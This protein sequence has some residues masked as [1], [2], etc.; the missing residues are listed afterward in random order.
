MALHIKRALKKGA[1]K[2]L[3]KAALT[4]II[5]I[6]LIQLIFIASTNT[7]VEAFI[8]SLDLPAGAPEASMS[9]SLS[10]PVSATI[11][12]VLAL[13][14]LLLL[15]VITVVL[16]RVMAA[17]RQVITRESYTRR[18]I[19][20]VFN[21]IIAGIIVGLLT[22]VGFVLL[23]IP[24]LFLMVSLLFTTVYIADQDEN[25][26][27][28][29][30]DSWSLASGNRWRLL[31]MY[32]A[33]LVGFFIITF[34]TGFILPAGSVLSTVVS[35]IINTIMVVYMMAVITDAYRQLLHEDRPREGGEPSP[36]VTTN[37][38]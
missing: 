1:T 34:A 31:G 7:L 14:T 24:G 27:S 16:I 28:A 17:D 38:S 26:L 30:Q 32:V 20:V 11:A 23:I 21:S 25:L 9:S 33:I 36:D 35:M 2:T 10:L 3:T 18:M 13:G 6:G 37:L 8:A 19:W 29:I 5:L 22:M 12:G 4:F 15:Q